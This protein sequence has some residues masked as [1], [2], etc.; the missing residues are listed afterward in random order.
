[1]HEFDFKKNKTFEYRKSESTRIM[2]KHN[3]KI[4][5]ILERQ[6]KSIDDSISTINKTKYLVPHNFSLGEFLYIIR[7]K[8]KM[9]PETAIFLFVNT[10]LLSASDLMCKIYDDNKDPDGFLYITYAGE[11]VFG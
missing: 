4:P 7:S 3:N 5:I 1:M 10:N 8:T 2:N 9:K 11:N 6:R